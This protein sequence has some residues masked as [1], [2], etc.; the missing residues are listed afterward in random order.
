MT[1]KPPLKSLKRLVPRS[2]VE[3]LTHRFSEVADAANINGLADGGWQKL[4]VVFYS[5]GAA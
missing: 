2:G 1:P 5:G 4:L 3:P